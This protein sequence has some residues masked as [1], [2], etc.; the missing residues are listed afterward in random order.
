MILNT[1]VVLVLTRKVMSEQRFE[2]VEISHMDICRNIPY[3]GK[4]HCKGPEAE[5]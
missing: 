2:A 5:A 3:R 4:Q 1:V